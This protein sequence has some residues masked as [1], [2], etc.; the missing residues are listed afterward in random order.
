ME[1]YIILGHENPDI[2][3]II[4]GYLLETLMK[5]KGYDAEFIIPDK[6][7]SK[8]DIDLSAYCG[9]DPTAYQKSLP[10]AADTKY[11]LVDHHER[12]V[13]GEIVAIIDHHPT[14]T[15]DIKCKYYYNL[16]YSIKNWWCDCRICRSMDICIFS[17][18]CIIFI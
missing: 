10:T 12:N 14:K 7:I 9:I 18:I 3:S 11:I 6:T 17:N 4:S 13:P 15:K 2:D 5:K 1:K 16:D 8:E